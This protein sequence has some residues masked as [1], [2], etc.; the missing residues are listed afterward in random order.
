MGKIL[1]FLFGKDNNVFNS[2]G[3]VQ[4]DLGKGKWNKWDDRFTKDPNYDFTQHS[5]REQ[6]KQ[7]PPKGR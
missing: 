6:K 2:K 3:K 7:T 4:H 1:D 5:A